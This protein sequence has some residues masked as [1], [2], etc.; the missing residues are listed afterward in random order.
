MRT[1]SRFFAAIFLAAAMS[2]CVAH[3]GSDTD[4]FEVT[5]TVLA[6][7][8]IVATDLAFGNY[9]PV[10]V[11][12]LDAETTLSVT[13]TNG[14]P[15]YVGMSLGD[16]AGASMA[17]RRMTKSGGAQTLDYVLYQDTQRSVLWGDTGVDRLSGTGD[18]SAN[19]LH[20]YG[21]IPIQQTAPAGNYTDNITVTV[22]W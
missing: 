18:G 16:G 17:T 15:Y 8:D 22:S 5:A 9:D 19:T 21:R 12:P 14:T 13:C 6:S 4:S 11:S 7:C 1:I 10:S 3:A 2:P 20:L